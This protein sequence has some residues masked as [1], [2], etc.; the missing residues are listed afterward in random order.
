[1]TDSSIFTILLGFF[2]QIY[3]L[4]D[5]IAIY[6]GEDF[7]ISLNEFFIA[8]CVL[9]IVIAALLNFAKSASDISAPVRNV[10]EPKQN[11]TP[12]VFVNYQGGLE[13]PPGDQSMI[14]K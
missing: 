13:L 1:M 8:L 6:H 14:L 4:C 10:K 11:Y 12:Y 2:Q 9:G 7:D 3:Q 5:Q